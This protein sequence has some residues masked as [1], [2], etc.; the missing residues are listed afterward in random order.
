VVRLRA[1]DLL[2]R[3][4]GAG[5]PLLQRQPR[6]EL[7]R[8]RGWSTVGN[9]RLQRALRSLEADLDGVPPRA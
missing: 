3:V 5:A 4:Q 8:R 6:D 7:R 2:S 1:A 9:L